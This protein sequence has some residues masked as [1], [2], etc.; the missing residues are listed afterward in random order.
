MMRA[1]HCCKP[2]QLRFPAIEECIDMAPLK[3]SQQRIASL[4]KLIDEL[5]EIDRLREKVIVA[6]LS[7]RTLSAMNTVDIVLPHQDVIGID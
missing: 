3:S 2:Q 7:A 6:A 4:S 1:L 5:R